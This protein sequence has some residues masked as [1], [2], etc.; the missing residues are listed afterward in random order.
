MVT[1]DPSALTGIAATALAWGLAMV[2]WIRQADQPVCRRL[3][4]LLVTEGVAV[5]SSG[6]VL[7]RLVG[8][9]MY[10]YLIQ[11]HFAADILLLA[12]YP[13]FIVNALELPQLARLRHPAVGRVLLVAAAGAI[14]ALVVRPDWYYV[15][16]G[17]VIVERVGWQIVGYSLGLM[18][19]AG[20]VLALIA[21]RSACCDL[22]RQQGA[23]FAAA[24]GVRDI[25]WGVTYLALATVGAANLGPLQYAMTMQA[26][27]GAI[28]VYVPLLVYAIL[29]TRLLDLDLRVKLTLQRG[30]VVAAFVAVFFLV[31]ET[32]ASILADWLGNVLGLLAAT[33]LVF[34]VAPLQEVAERIAD[35]AMPRVR[36]TPEYLAFKKLQLYSAA[37]ESVLADREVTERERAMLDKMR[38]TLGIDHGDARRLED[39]IYAELRARR[40]AWAAGSKT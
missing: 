38:T 17:G 39:D 32:A 13:P 36:E 9:A 12:L 2:L 31:S 1:W 29:K 25:V 11:V 7:G 21:W 4:A 19:F 37:I 15:L 24:F 5:A 6:A 8:D 34:F 35:R 22:N 16:V 10:P 27:A 23:W 40:K 3:V 14:A 18:F 33:V 30:T 28:L 26:Y 20:L